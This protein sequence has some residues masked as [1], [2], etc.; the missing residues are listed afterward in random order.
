[1]G[2]PFFVFV[3]ANDRQMLEQSSRGIVLCESF[4]NSVFLFYQQCDSIVIDLII[5]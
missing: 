3:G 1:M 4:N 5:Q 2:H